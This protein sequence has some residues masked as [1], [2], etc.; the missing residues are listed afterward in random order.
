MYTQLSIEDYQEQFANNADADY[1]LID[2][3]EE[4]EFEAGHLPG[5]ILLPLGEIQFRMDEVDEEK[6]VVL[7]CRTGVRSDMAAQLLFANGYD[8][9]YNL[10]EGTMGW[11]NRGLPIER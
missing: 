10:M 6:P 2:V 1:V 8:N 9:I 7:V 4:E 5:A 11:V 3:R